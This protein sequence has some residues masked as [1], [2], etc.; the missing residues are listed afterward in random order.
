MREY[1]NKPMKS[2]FITLGNEKVGKGYKPFIIAEM[3]GNHN[4]SLTRALE[5]VEAAVASGADALKIQTYTAD[6]MTLDLESGDFQIKDKNSPWANNSLY[7]LYQKAYTPWEWHKEIFEKCKKLGILAF[8]TPFDET[9][10][11]FL[12]K[13]NVPFYKIA[14]FENNDLPLIKKIAQTGKPIII[15]TGLATKE[16]LKDAV[17]TAKENGCK[18]LVLLKCTSSYPASPVDSNINTIPDLRKQFKCEVGLS[19]HSL[20]IGVALASV[21]LGAAVIEKHFTLSRKDGGVDASFSLEPKEFKELVVESLSAWQSLGKISYGPTISEKKSIQYRRSLYVSEDMK[22]GE[23]FTKKN[24]R[25][26]RP[27]FGLPPKYFEKILGKKSL[28][29]VKKGTPLTWKM[30]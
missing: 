20:G 21:S 30:F 9:A 29:P 28:I 27:G 5:I 24:L 15:S 7:K 19:D 17:N 6:T 4:Q 14:S 3:S 13:L 8:S 1:K 26:V 10:V 11:D 2:D 22:A 12:E 18:E 23:V 25:R 16:E